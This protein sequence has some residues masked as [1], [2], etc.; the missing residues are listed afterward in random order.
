MLP[1]LS[2]LRLVFFSVIFIFFLALLLSILSNSLPKLLARVIPLS[3]EHLP[4]LPLPLYSRIICPFCHCSG[5]SLLSA[6]VCSAFLYPLIVW[7][8]ALVNISFG[9]S[10]GPVAFPFFSLCIASV[11]SVVRIGSM[12][13]FIPSDSVILFIVVS[14]SLFHSAYW[15]LPS[16]AWYRFSKYCA[17]C[18]VASA[19]SSIGWLLSFSVMYELLLCLGVIFLFSFQKSCDFVPPSLLILLAR[20]LMF[21]L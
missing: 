9:I 14:I 13:S 17:M 20:S 1:Y 6:I 11:S 4:L 18:S 5:M 8:S 19:G 15:G 21:S 7:G 3:F 16:L 12:S 10:S 2:V